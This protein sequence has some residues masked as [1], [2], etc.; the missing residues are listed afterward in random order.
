MLKPILISQFDG[1]FVSLPN[2]IN[3][4]NLT[5]VFDNSANNTTLDIYDLS[6]KNVYTK[7]FFGAGLQAKSM[8]IPNLNKGIYIVALNSKG[9]TFKKKLVVQ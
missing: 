9:S 5:I 8:K 1:S 7:L 6:G 4:T 3:N 2:P